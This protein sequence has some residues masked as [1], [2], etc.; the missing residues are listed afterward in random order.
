R[1]AVDRRN[2]RLA[3]ALVKDLGA[4]IRA[5]YPIV[6]IVTPVLE[7]RLQCNQRT[8]RIGPPDEQPF[9]AIAVDWGC[10]WLSSAM[11]GRS[12]DQKIQSRKAGVSH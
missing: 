8:P 10:H 4:C 3:K 12:V 1:V 6:T 9:A 7:R 2:L 5:G 11:T